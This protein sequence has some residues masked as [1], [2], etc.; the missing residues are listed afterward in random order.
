MRIATWNMDHWRRPADLRLRAWA[1][2][3]NQVRPDVALLQETNPIGQFPGLVYRSEG[4]HDDRSSEP[5][6]LGWGSAV[7][8]FGPSL[9]R[10]DSA[11]SPF[12]SDPNPILRTFP[13]SVAVAEI[14]GAQPLVVVSAYGVID[15]G[16]AD[17]TV[18]RILSDLA[19]LVDERRSRGIVIA[20]DLNI[21]SQWSS[22]HRSFLKGRHEECLARDLNLFERFEVLGFHNLV[23]RSDS[24]LPGCECHAGTNCR[25]VQTQRHER[26][27]FPWQNDYIFVTSDILERK[28]VLEVFDQEEAWELSGHCPIVIEFSDTITA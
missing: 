11:V 16:Y 22:K 6:D 19:P 7:V 18:H 10:L 24:P 21:T 15:R 9:R 20:G 1:Y 14:Q 26:S 2:L 27:S 5:K 3:R 17:S 12:R 8:S 13:G 28:P 25:H 4:I 23:L